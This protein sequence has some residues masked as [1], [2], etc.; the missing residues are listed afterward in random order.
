M[1]LRNLDHRRNFGRLIAR[2][3]VS[4]PSTILVP[5]D[6]PLAPAELDLGVYRAV[7]YPPHRS[8]LSESQEDLPL[9]DQPGLLRRTGSPSRPLIRMD[10][11]D[12]VAADVVQIDFLADSF[13]RREGT[14][15]PPLAL[16]FDIVNGFIARFRTLGRAFQI[17][18]LV[19][20]ST[21]WRIQYLN[22]DETELEPEE[23][24]F[25]A[26]VGAS[27][28]VELVGLSR[29]LWERIQ[30]LSPTYEPPPSD[31]LLLDAFGRLPHVGA[32]V[33]L[34]FSALEV[35]IEAAL[36]DLSRIHGVRKEVWDWIN[37]RGDYRKEP[38]IG[39]KFDSFL[40][41]V[42]GRTLKEDVRLWE[43][44]QN[45]RAARNGFA[46]DGVA[47]IG[48]DEVDPRR[49]V[50]LLQAAGEILDW[51]DSLLPETLRRPRHDQPTNYEAVTPL[52][53][54]ASPEPEA[55][56]ET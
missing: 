6:E 56:A 44:F 25:R 18:E 35:R 48:G 13:D 16:V 3:H 9:T 33:V 19:P 5:A 2:T 20:G 40:K 7:L 31:Q 51:V 38:S 53:G 17:A 11:E 1:V 15:D 54:P 24:S 50:Q 55:T 29:P 45:L 12:V 22:D 23:G 30:D 43:A 36:D 21:T 34:G 37:D 27:F 10:E 42:T 47:R 26:R 28:S 39:E 4:L 41:A 46:H 49:A 14:D 52:T 32:A 8:E